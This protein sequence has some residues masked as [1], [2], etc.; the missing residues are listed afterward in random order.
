MQNWTWKS[1]L[2]HT[3]IQVQYSFVPTIIQYT[4]SFK[5]FVVYF[6]FTFNTLA[7]WARN[8]SKKYIENPKSIRNQKSVCTSCCS[9]YFFHKVW[10]II[11]KAVSE[12][13]LNI[14]STTVNESVNTHLF[15]QQQYIRTAESEE[16][17][18]LS[19][20]NVR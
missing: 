14:V 8:T 16:Q 4:D 9:I 19:I 10:N 17:T 1:C 20:A 6:N 11:K 3:W 15:L 2:L 12:S 5:M 13:N 18:D 7:I